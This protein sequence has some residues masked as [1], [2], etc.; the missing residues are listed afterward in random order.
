M[1][2]KLNME[3]KALNHYKTTMGVIFNI[4]KK[5]SVIDFYMTYTNI[6][7]TLIKLAR[8]KSTSCR[9]FA[10]S[11]EKCHYQNHWMRNFRLFFSQFGFL[12]ILGKFERQCLKTIRIFQ[13]F[14]SQDTRKFRLTTWIENGEGFAVHL[15]T[16][17]SGAKG[18]WRVSSW[19]AISNKVKKYRIFSRVLLRLFSGLIILV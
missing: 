4:K 6:S 1:A 5:L 12:Y 17:P 15:L 18:E 10:L 14:T 13:Y 7:A 16:W 8:G 3:K 2:I 11:C 19:L 9:F